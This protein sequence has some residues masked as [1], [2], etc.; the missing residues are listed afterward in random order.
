MDGTT[1]PASGVRNELLGVV[2]ALGVPAVGVPA[3]GVLGGMLG[4]GGR[5]VAIGMLGT[6]VP[7][8]GTEEV[9]TGSGGGIE[10]RE[11]GPSRY[12]SLSWYMSTARVTKI[13]ATAAAGTASNTPK[14]PKI[15]PPTKSAISTHISGKPTDLPMMRGWITK[16]S[17]A[18]TMA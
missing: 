18:C 4:G 3:V 12:R 2:V 11:A 5:L 6:V 9:R 7:P 15:S 1:L 14:N 8:G 17:S 10:R 16:P 13:L